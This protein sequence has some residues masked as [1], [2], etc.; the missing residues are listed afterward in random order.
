MVNKNNNNYDKCSAVQKE[1]FLRVI[2]MKNVSLK[3]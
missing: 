1:I 3:V 2:N